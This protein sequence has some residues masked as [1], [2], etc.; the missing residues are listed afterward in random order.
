ML[1]IKTK[2][3]DDLLNEYIELKSKLI[4]KDREIY[5][6]IEEETLILESKN[7]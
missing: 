1:S 7:T 5:E 3:I 4:A 6:A 2:K